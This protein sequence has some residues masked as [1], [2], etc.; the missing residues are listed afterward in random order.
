MVI[1]LTVL[2]GV[3]G[4]SAAGTATRAP[5]ASRSAFDCPCHVSS[6][7]THVWVTN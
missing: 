5:S 3:T 2:A 6:D 1:L 7:G 4:Q